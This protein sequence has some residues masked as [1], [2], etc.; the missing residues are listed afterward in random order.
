MDSI[1]GTG[2]A[3]SLQFF[4]LLGWLHLHLS[5]LLSAG[6]HSGVKFKAIL[7]LTPT[8]PP[9]TWKLFSKGAASGGDGSSDHSSLT[10]ETSRSSSPRPPGALKNGLH[11]EVRP[12]FYS[13]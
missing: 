4:F 5:D 11:S 12:T 7:F 2:P 3:E 9:K 10:L 1:R 8:S 6:G 13:Q